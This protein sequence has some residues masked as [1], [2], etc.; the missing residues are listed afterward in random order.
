MTGTMEEEAT[1]QDDTVAREML[2]AGAVKELAGELRLTDVVDLITF[3]R[4]D[5][6]PNLG[7]LVNSSAELYFAPGSLCYGWG[8]S[9]DMLW[10]DVPSVKLDLEFHHRQV[11]AFFRLTLQP[12]QAGVDLVHIAFAKPDGDPAANTR[13][14]VDAIREARR[15]SVL[16][17]SA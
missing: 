4:T 2:L 9:V 7:D 14:L 3:I 13:C 12:C 8:A 17:H 10:T 5:N 1:G 6:H 16:A 15:G 11:T